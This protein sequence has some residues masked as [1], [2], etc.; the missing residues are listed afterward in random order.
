MKKGIAITITTCALAV[1]MGLVACGGSSATSSAS[2]SASSAAASASASASASAASASSSSASSASA[3]ASSASA[4]ASSSASSSSVASLDDI[5][6]YEGTFENGDTILYGIENGT[7]SISI[8][9]SPA[10]TARAD[11]SIIV[12]ALPTVG[13]DGVTTLVG[14]NGTEL[15]FTMSDDGSSI[16]VDGYGVATLTPVTKDDLEKEA[17]EVV[18]SLDDILYYEGTFENGNSLVYGVEDGTGKISVA[19]I[20]AD[21]SEANQSVIVEAIPTVN[22]DGV[23]TLVGE[24][25][26][27]LSFKMAEDGSSID[28]DG[29][30]VATLTPVTKADFEKEMAEAAAQ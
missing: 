23:I 17:A 30:G 4:S 6:Y 13:A 26:T 29:Y 3:S 12:M 19:I 5:L 15:S 14:E 22:A 8:A 11:E 16:E 28:V 1:S 27:E 2:A 7:G 25:G 9:I 21:A 24:D 18:S 20:P 10:D